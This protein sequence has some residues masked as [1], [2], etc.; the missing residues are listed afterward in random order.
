MGLKPSRISP[1][2]MQRYI[3]SAK[4]REQSRLE[5]LQQRQKK[6]LEVAHTAAR[7]LKNE[8]AATQVILFGSL[9]RDDFHET[10]DIDLA[11]VGL[12]ERQYF[13]AVA[14][15]ISL[16]EFAL[17]LV[18]TQHANPEITFA[19]TQGIEL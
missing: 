19:I 7:I 13:K 4:A 16:S 15:L 1:E 18:E 17:D 3:T 10:S 14:R 8:F 2:Q 11:V 9:L 6:G 5:T 12:P